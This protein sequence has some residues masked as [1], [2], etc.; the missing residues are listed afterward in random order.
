[1]HLGLVRPQKQ[2]TEM[3]GWCDGSRAD[4]DEKRRSTTDLLLSAG[5]PPILSPLLTTLLLN[6]SSSPL[7]CPQLF[8]VFFASLLSC[9]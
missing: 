8:A 7:Q 6:S 1:M 3:V 2:L 5:H 9:G 4:L